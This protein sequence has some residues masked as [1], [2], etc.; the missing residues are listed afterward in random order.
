ML[1]DR[2]L[3]DEPQQAQILLVGADHLYGELRISDVHK[4]KIGKDHRSHDPPALARMRTA[5][6]T[7]GGC[8]FS[9]SRN[10]TVPLFNF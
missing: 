3:T 7:S 5:A 4:W 1:I 10:R 6:N 9:L 2:S 8:R